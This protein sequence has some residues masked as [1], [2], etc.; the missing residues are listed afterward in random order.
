VQCRSEGEP[1]LYVSDPKGMSRAMRR[2]SLD[3]LARLNELELREFGD[4]ETLTRIAQ[5]ELAYRMQ[6]SVPGAMDLAQEPKHILEMYGAQPGEASFA[7]NCLQARRLVERGVRYVQ[8]FDWGWDYHGT[9]ADTG[10]TDGLTTKCATMDRP[11]A[12]LIKDL[13]QRG[14]L[15]ETL[16]IWGGEFGRTPFREG[17]TAGSQILGRDH[18][19]DCFTMWL[20]GGG[21]KGGFAHGS[22]DELGFGVTEQPV[23]VHDLQATILHLLG[24]NHDRLTF[25]FQG[26]DYRLTDVHGHVVQDLIA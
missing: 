4:P 1:I 13:K 21:V 15:D 23:H 3:A 12:A 16:V 18:Y 25:R 20:A 10:L 11:V 8:L 26:R 22:T 9:G 7:N 19:P 5:Y 6:V 24:F 14:L 17:R 2:R